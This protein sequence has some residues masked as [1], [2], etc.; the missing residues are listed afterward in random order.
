MA[1]DYAKRRPNRRILTAGVGSSRSGKGGGGRS[2]NAG[3]LKQLPYL[4][5]GVVLGLVIAGFFYIKMQP[6]QVAHQTVTEEED[7]APPPKA[8]KAKK[9]KVAHR[10][11]VETATAQPRY[12]F[13]TMLTKDKDHDTDIEEDH[14]NDADDEAEEDYAEADT[15]V[16]TAEK[17][18]PTKDEPQPAKKATTAAAGKYV[19]QIASLK[20]HEEADRLK[21]RLTLEG[22]DVFVSKQKV[23]NTTYYRVYLGP[24]RTAENARV[25]QKR[26]KHCHINSF[27]VTV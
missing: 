10:K 6:M 25:Q 15:K 12:D 26:L 22:H 24:Y 7:E 20:K 9:T 17:A 4:L 16:K 27:L 19:L 2:R 8:V 14:Y 18:S 11:K 13:Y 21:A 1:K 3:V 5:A 23:N